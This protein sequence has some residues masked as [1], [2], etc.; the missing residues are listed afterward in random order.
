MPTWLIIVCVVG[1]FLLMGGLFI[2]GIVTGGQKDAGESERVQAFVDAHYSVL[3]QHGFTRSKDGKK[4]LLT[5]QHANRGVD[6]E[7]YER[8]FRAS[9]M[10]SKVSLK[11][12]PNLPV[13]LGF[14][15]DVDQLSG[16]FTAA[17]ARDNALVANG[18][19]KADTK[20]ITDA[21]MQTIADTLKRLGGMVRITPGALVWFTNDDPLPADG[22]AQV[23]ALSALA[24][25]L[26]GR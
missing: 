21:Q 12:V 16:A 17:A 15:V 1:G 26:E 19:T 9:D 6:I 4:A 11:A 22:L 3:L 10:H 24:D 7:V 25:A 2:Y 5:G 8:N 13:K 20:A 18:V 23:K 14:E